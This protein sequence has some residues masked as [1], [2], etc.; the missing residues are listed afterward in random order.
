[1]KE[2]AQSASGF[3]VIEEVGE[4]R[5]IA[6]EGLGYLWSEIP[7]CSAVNDRGQVTEWEEKGQKRILFGEDN[8]VAKELL[9]VDTVTLLFAKANKVIIPATATV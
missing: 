5:R 1:M 6:I 2:L 7:R 3:V 8:L 9:Y 4:V